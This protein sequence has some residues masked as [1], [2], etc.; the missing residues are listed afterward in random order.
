MRI[1]RGTWY[2]IPEGEVQVIPLPRGD[3]PFIERDLETWRSGPLCFVGRLEPRK[4][5]LELVDAAVRMSDVDPT[6]EFTFIGGDL[7]LLPDLSMKT[8]IEARIPPRLRRRVSSLGSQPRA[9][10][11]EHLGRAR[12]AVVPSRWENFPNTCLEAMA[13]GLPVTRVAER[14]DDRHGRRRR[15]GVGGLVRGP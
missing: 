13:T 11:L 3:T 5:V 10:L 8:A 14:R 12:V 4:G 7:L 15:V 1:R 9:Q 6:L 2:G